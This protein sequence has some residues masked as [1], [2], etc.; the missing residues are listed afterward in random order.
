MGRLNDAVVGK[1]IQHLGGDGL[2]GGQIDNAHIAA[3]N[4]VTKSLDVKVAALA[5]VP[6]VIGMIADIADLV[7]EPPGN[8][9]VV[10][11]PPVAV[12]VVVVGPVKTLLEDFLRRTRSYRRRI[13]RCSPAL[14]VVRLDHEGEVLF[15]YV[16]AGNL[17]VITN[18][19]FHGVPLSTWASQRG[20][21]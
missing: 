8:G 19:D 12:P 2:T 14:V 16:D 5:M 20:D 15:R 18:P 11:V 3:V 1:G 7:V 13:I 21:T 4:A 9:V 6:R 10:G 17:V